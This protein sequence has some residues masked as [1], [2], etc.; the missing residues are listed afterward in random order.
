MQ[1][2]ISGQHVEITEAIHDFVEKK[3]T[4]LQAH[5][6]NLTSV[7][8]VLKVEKHLQIAEAQVTFPGHSVHAEADS[9]DLYKTIDLLVDKLVKQLTKHKEKMTDHR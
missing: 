6:S 3:L 7:Q 8:V 4:K 2:Q 9:E 1:I 5:M